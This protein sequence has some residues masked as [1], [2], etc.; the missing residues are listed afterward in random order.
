MVPWKHCN[1]SLDGEK[2]QCNLTIITGMPISRR[3]L[4]HSSLCSL[5]TLTWRRLNRS[6]SSTVPVSLA[7]SPSSFASS[8]FS[9]RLASWRVIS[10]VNDNNQT[11]TYNTRLEFWRFP[12]EYIC[13]F[14]TILHYS[15]CAVEEPHEVAA[16]SQR[17][18]YQRGLSDSTYLVVSPDSLVSSSPSF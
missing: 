17:E 15:Y 18:S 10:E 8:R 13:R 2:V 1:F 9:K 5:V 16:C 4:R 7:S 12:I 14:Y 6:I 3:S 11:E